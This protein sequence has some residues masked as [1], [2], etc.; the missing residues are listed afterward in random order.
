MKPE[1]LNKILEVMK[2]L[3]PQQKGRQGLALAVDCLN[4]GD[5][6]QARTVLQSIDNEYYQRYLWKDL[7]DPDISRYLSDLVKV[8]G[9]DLTLVHPKGDA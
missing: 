9:L 8:F 2:E 5:V 3:A 6:Y 1:E 7:D 4:D